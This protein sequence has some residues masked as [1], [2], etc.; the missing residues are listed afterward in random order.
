MK[1]ISCFNQLIRAESSSILALIY[2]LIPLPRTI[3]TIY[4]AVLGLTGCVPG[5]HQT[6]RVTLTTYGTKL[7]PD[8][9][10]PGEVT[11]II[12]NNATDL[13]HE[14]FL[15]QTDLAPDKLPVGDDGKIDEDSLHF[16]KIVA[17]E[18]LKP[19]SGRVISVT[20]KPGHYVYFC[21]IDAHHMSGMRG[22][23]TIRH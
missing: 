6:V 23:F 3:L 11:F 1:L 8:K 22:E 9:I 16:L 17:A 14:F 21:N 5:D 13:V 4:V 19:G 18:D 10:R 2:M 15:V 7:T 12:K 20:L